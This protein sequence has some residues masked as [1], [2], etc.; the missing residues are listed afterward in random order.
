MDMRDRPF[1]GP[2]C[3]NTIGSAHARVCKVPGEAGTLSAEN[4]MS[5]EKARPRKKA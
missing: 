3:I 5:H 1:E 2:A 4:R